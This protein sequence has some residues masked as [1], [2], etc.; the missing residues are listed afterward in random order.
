MEQVIVNL[1]VNARDAM[2]SGGRLLIESKNMDF[3][4]ALGDNK[5][6][7]PPGR[8]VSLAVSDTGVGIDAETQARVFEPFFTTKAAGEGTG[9]GLATVYGIVRQSG[10]FISLYSEPGQGTSF[11]IF[12][13][14]VDEA[15]EAIG[16]VPASAEAPR[17]DET[18]LVVEDAPA[19]RTLVRRVLERLGYHVL[20]AEDGE[21]AMVL[22]L[23]YDGPIHLLVTDVIMPRMGGRA[24]ADQFALARPDARVLFVSGY[25]DDAVM[26]HGVL[27]PTVHYLE[28]P[29]T[30]DTLARKVRRVLDTALASRA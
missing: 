8:Y 17:G 30:P 2:P 29:F 5:T 1:A 28:K 9:L 25:T 11:K 16:H 21:S 20:V 26:Q 15:V 22:S 6:P 23:A 18:I 12:F 19:V 14:R 27:E 10:G 4:E 13:P 7:L 24:L 3:T